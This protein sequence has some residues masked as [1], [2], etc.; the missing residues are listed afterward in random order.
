MRAH[1]KIPFGDLGNWADGCQSK[2]SHTFYHV[3]LTPA[4]SGLEPL[5]G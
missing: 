4:L 3:P 1:E 5:C 2:E